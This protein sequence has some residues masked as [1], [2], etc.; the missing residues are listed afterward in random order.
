MRWVTRVGARSWRAAKITS[1]ASASIH[2]SVRCQL[3]VQAEDPPM[4]PPA[5]KR[6]RI[7][8][9]QATHVRRLRAFRHTGA[10]G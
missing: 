4:A 6:G 5:L 10:S 8:E 3:V 2:G 1:A 7:P 9:H